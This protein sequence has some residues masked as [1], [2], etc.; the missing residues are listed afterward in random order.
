MNMSNIN[1]CTTSGSQTKTRTVVVRT[2]S[3]SYSLGTVHCRPADSGT[4]QCWDLNTAV[5]QTNVPWL[6]VFTLESLKVTKL[7][8]GGRY[9]LQ[10]ASVSLKDFL[11]H[12]MNLPRIRS[13]EKFIS[14]SYELSKSRIYYEYMRGNYTH[15][16]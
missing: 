6:Y 3:K 12:D 15:T 4:K 1:I 5:V 16:Y 9:K 13:S 8:N 14:R 11:L 10:L 7:N 2:D